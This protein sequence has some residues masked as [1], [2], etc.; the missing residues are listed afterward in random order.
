MT[1]NFR[2]TDNIKWVSLDRQVENMAHTGSYLYSG[3]NDYRYK[4]SSKTRSTIIPLVYNK[5]KFG[6]TRRRRRLS[7]KNKP[8]Y[9]LG[10]DNQYPNFLLDLLTK[11]V[12]HNAAFTR[13]TS[14][15]MG[16][17][18]THK[19]SD[20]GEDFI[21][22]LKSKGL[23]ENTTRSIFEQ[24]ACF[25]GAY[26]KMNF[27]EPRK[28][29]VRGDERDLANIEAYKYEN[30][31]VGLLETVD[32]EHDEF[33]GE[34]MNETQ[35]YWFCPDYSE[36]KMVRDELM[37]IPKYF[38]YEDLLTY[39]RYL[40]K[41]DKSTYYFDE[42][43]QEHLN[44]GQYMHMIAKPSIL[45]KH[46]PRA[47]Y[48]TD[49]SIDSILL[50]QALSAFDVAGLKNGL[51]AGYI[52]TIPV[53]GIEKIKRTNPEQF[54]EI[55]AETKE[56]VARELEGAENNQATLVVLQDV[57]TKNQKQASIEITKIPDNNNS[58]I[59]EIIQGRMIAKILTA[60][61]VTD[62]RL[63]GAPQIVAQGFANQ[64]ETLVVSWEI[65]MGTYIYPEL[66]RPVE[67]FVNE[68]LK[69]IYI[70][71]KG[72]ISDDFR[73][74]IL[75]RDMFKDRPSEDL[76]KEILTLN[77]LRLYYGFDPIDEASG[78]ELVTENSPL[79]IGIQ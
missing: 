56:K 65:W 69:P 29:R 49:A 42:K 75:P 66:V 35:F 16:N 13:A 20:Q 59:H 37:G 72:L 50:D 36:E 10:I 2:V 32:D 47:V 31:R 12:F 39:D 30:V 4:T 62:P 76:L 43:G 77:E 33:D 25:G 48:E 8:F 41:D 60:W 61:G 14:L 9:P 15:A 38:G 28:G 11:S 57:A 54:D 24:I 23:D 55:V 40:V 17:G 5:Y 71:E 67:D 7:F 45:S 68:I 51:T 22:W 74:V 1:D 73:A 64:A 46:Y 27:G 21:Q 52:V 53:P 78:N 34:Y 44:F 3:A 58:E 6:D 70:Q 18:W 26:I 79:D 19:G 63:I